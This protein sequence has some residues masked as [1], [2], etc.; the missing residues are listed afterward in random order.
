MNAKS[1]RTLSYVCLA[2][3]LLILCLYWRVYEN[4]FVNFDDDIYVY[5]NEHIR[6]GLSFDSLRWAFSS[7]NYVYYQPLTWVSHML[8]IDWFGLNPGRHHLVSVI[9]HGLSSVGVLLWLFRTTGRIWCSTFAASLF[10][11][12]PLR[13]ESVAWIAERKDV[14]STFFFVLALLA[15]SSYTKRPSRGGYAMVI[16]ALVLGLLS[17]PMLV[18]APFLFLIADFW[19]LQRTVPI[20]SLVREKIP[21]FVLAG[22]SSVLTYVGQE[23]SG[24]VGALRNVVFTQRLANA[25]VSYSRYIDKL[26]WPH[27]LAV[28][29]PF[30]RN[31]PVLW[32]AAAG[33]FL[34]VMSIAVIAAR[35]RYPFLFFGWWW[36]VVGLLPVIGVVQAGVQSFADRFSYIPSL[37]LFVAIVWAAASMATRIRRG[38]RLASSAGVC[39]LAVFS[40]VSY[41]QIA[42]WHDSVTL[43]QH[44]VDTTSQ[45]ALAEHN[46]GL[47][48]A[49]EG[50]NSEA[51][52]HLMRAVSWEPHHFQ[53]HYN[54]GKA[55]AAEGQTERAIVSFTQAIATKNDYA[56][57][58]FARATMYHKLG[59]RTMAKA[60]YEGAVKYPLAVPYR[61]E[62]YNNLGVSSAEAGD[63]ST[64]V[65]N[66]RKAAM[67]QPELVSA[68][69]NL[70][71]AL[72]QAGKRDE[73][74][75]QL[76]RADVAT[77]GDP[78]IRS[79]LARFQGS[80]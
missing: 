28:L 57:A 19:P 72:M 5:G 18:V 49:E 75:L 48:L 23:Q 78:A 62:A 20:W 38:P 1:Q 52:P 36:Y 37:G 39:A 2:L 80:K 11:L 54:L 33:L 26:F 58:Y 7:F 71:T 66:F 32:V 21:M 13:V 63:I 27:P 64:A 15:Y 79:T 56:E 8:D 76:E 69:V 68:Q 25:T 16:G 10:A 9:F 41:G 50:R 4:G 14:L 73:A 22:V 34:L 42:Y 74:V 70:A 44:A 55:L 31:L 40:V 46:L 17:K 35:Q 59:N 43:F 67:L 51:I 3:F 60:D 65:N 45:N 12:H 47:A 29:Y 30:N 61:A 53:A 77:H 24:A 6:D